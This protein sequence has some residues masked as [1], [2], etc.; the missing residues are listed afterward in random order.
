MKNYNIY[1]QVIRAQNADNMRNAENNAMHGNG[2]SAWH[3]ERC[4]RCLFRRKN[5]EREEMKHRIHTASVIG[6]FVTLVLLLLMAAGMDMQGGWAAISIAIG[7]FAGFCFLAG[8]TGK[9]NEL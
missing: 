8:A 4:E 5:R 3:G 6:A 1:T 9:D 2:G 7:I